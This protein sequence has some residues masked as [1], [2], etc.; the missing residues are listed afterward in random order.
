MRK[1]ILILTIFTVLFPSCGGKK[2]E[3]V[4]MPPMMRRSRDIH[5]FYYA[6]YGTPEIDGA[7]NHWNH[8]IYRQ[9]SESA[10]YP[11]GKDIGSSFYPAYGCYSSHDPKVLESH[12]AQIASVQVGVICLSWWGIDSFSDKAVPAILSAAEKFGVKVNFHIE[13]FEGRN[14]LATREAIVYI[15]DRY[16][17]HNAFYRTDRFEKRPLFYISDSHLI[18]PSKWAMLLSPD[19]EYSIRGTEHDAII[20]G[21]W[22]EEND[23][24]KLLLGH[25]DG[26]YTYFG[27]DGLSYGS[28]TDNWPE[29]AQWSWENEMIFI[30]CVAPGYDDTRIRPWN[31]KNIRERQRG[32][33]FS[34][35]F[36]DALATT[37]VFIGITSFN[38]WHEGTQ[39]EPAIPYE[40]PGYKYKDYEGQSPF[41]YLSKIRESIYGFAK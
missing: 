30:P 23:G 28:T 35:M 12:M 21:L 38:Q 40:I 6:W 16:G 39:V 15:L 19:G 7:W 14:A 4:D 34:K 22:V 24:E 41:F 8:R 29:L 17:R 11:G 3:I 1:I 2:E 5:I 13:P 9:E 27:S 18:P 33:Y 10:G 25:F 20:I 32:K 37:P 26:Y 36:Q 31:H